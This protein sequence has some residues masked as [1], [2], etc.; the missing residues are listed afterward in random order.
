M[1]VIV[2]DQYCILTLFKQSDLCSIKNRQF[3]EESA[4]N[5]FF[6]WKQ[7][8]FIVNI[9]YRLYSFI[10]FIISEGIFCLINNFVYYYYY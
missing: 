10:R 9:F 5:I 2:K 8:Y 6:L 4:I 3:S 7:M 1:I